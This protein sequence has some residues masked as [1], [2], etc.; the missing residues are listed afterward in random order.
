MIDLR[1]DTATKPSRAM[2]EAMADAGVGDDQR[3]E[4]PTVLELERRAAEL[5]GQD[6]AVYLPTASMANDQMFRSWWATYL[7]ASASPG[8][9]AEVI[10]MNDDIDLR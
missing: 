10:R 6:E 8:A 5:L 9:A 3:R 4:D 1:S 2:R 7:R